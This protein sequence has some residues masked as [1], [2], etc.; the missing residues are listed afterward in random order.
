MRINL[1][2]SANRF[3]TY[4]ALTLSL[5]VGPRGSPYDE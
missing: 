4:R 3:I 2:D 5:N 1:L